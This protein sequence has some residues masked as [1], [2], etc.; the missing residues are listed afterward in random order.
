MLA[1]ALIGL[2][3]YVFHLATR[4]NELGRSGTATDA[5]LDALEHRI[6]ALLGKG[7]WSEAAIVLEE[8]V[9]RYPEDLQIRQRLAEI[10]QQLAATA[11]S[12]RQHEESK[13]LFAQAYHQWAAIIEIGPKDAAAYFRAAMAAN[14][15]GLPEARTL[16]EHAAALEPNR[17]E[18]LLNLGMVQYNVGEYDV[19]QVSL[20]RATQLKPDL[21]PG[22]A[23]LAQIALREGQR[24]V[25]LQL[26][27]RARDIDPIDANFR[28]I[29]ADIVA[30]TDPD[31][32]IALLETLTEELR[33]RDDVLRIARNAYGAKGRFRDAAAYFTSAS[34]HDPENPDLALA[35]ADLL[36][37]SGQ[38]DRAIE[39]ARRAV[40]AGHTGAP[41]M[42]ERLLAAGSDR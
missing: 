25:A 34:D 26:I 39:Y 31:R 21:A 4:P 33:R 8:A 7:Q 32:A 2:T 22:W 29:E 37:R 13:R 40:E 14:E 9:A 36:D 17:P 18:Y 1:F 30:S 20:H 6:H 16:F 15:A 38:R 10:Y 12:R 28:V 11:K 41:R 23:M 35:A 27:T 3:G 24:N 19:A 42:L 5:T